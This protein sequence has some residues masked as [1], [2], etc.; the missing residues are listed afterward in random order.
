MAGLAFR[1]AAIFLLAALPARAADWLILSNVT[2][3]DGTGAPARTVE[4][5]TVRDGIIQ[6]E[7]GEP[8]PGDVVTAVD[9]A[10]AYVM[11]GLIDTHVHIGRFPKARDEAVRIMGEAVRGGVTAVRDLGGDARAL[12]EADRARR[13]GE[14]AGPALAWSAMIGA[15]SLYEKDNRLGGHALGHAPG[16]APW[17]RAVT[18]RT[19]LRLAVAEAKGA[20][21]HALKLYGDLD[22]RLAA[23][24]IAEARRQGLLTVAHATLFPAGPGDL[25][26][27]GI[28]TLSHAPYLVW[29]GAGAIPDDYAMRTAGPWTEIAPDHPKLMALYRRMARE[30]VFL[31]ATLFVYR[32]MAKYSPAVEA[33]WTGPAFA[34]AMKAAGL[35]HGEGV[36]ITTGTDWFEPRGPHELPHTH[37]ELALLVEAGLTPM[38]AIVA[39][40]RNGARA[41]GIDDVRGTLR[42]GKAADMLILNADPLEDIRNTTKIR[43][44]VKDGRIVKPAR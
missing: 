10:G 32:D 28:G 13:N 27:A 30:G 15:P 18:P 17:S 29:E 8:G 20:G 26:A 14:I 7:A 4:T 21:A 33:G 42:P 24:L 11:P 43:F 31:D 19:D 2:L 1:I 6:D 37:E 38:E 22:A 39:G 34:W 40:T 25:V 35:A 36:Q 12:A 41:M 9:L 5:L 23:R 44:V 16:A 3:I